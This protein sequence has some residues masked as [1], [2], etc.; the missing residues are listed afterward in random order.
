MEAN[1]EWELLFVSLFEKLNLYFLVA[2]TPGFAKQPQFTFG[3]GYEVDNLYYFLC[4]EW[5]T[6]WTL[7]Y[8]P[9]NEN[10]RKI[11]DEILKVSLFRVEFKLF[12]EMQRV[13][14]QQIL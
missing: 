12:S 4:C 11:I 8:K 6:G 3:R 7:L 10:E 14:N 1:L 13:F 9:I 5:Q 2:A